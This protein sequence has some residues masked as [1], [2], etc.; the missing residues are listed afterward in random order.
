MTLDE[1]IQKYNNG[2]WDFDGIYSY[3]CKDLFSYFNR[4]VANNPTYIYGNAYEMYNNAPEALYEKIPKTPNFIPQKGDWCV[5]EQSYGGWGHIGMVISA[6]INTQ[7]IMSQNSGGHQDAVNIKRYNYHKVKGYLR[8]KGGNMGR[9]VWDNNV[10]VILTRG[11]VEEG[12]SKCEFPYTYT[13]NDSWGYFQKLFDFVQNKYKELRA[14]AQKYNDLYKSA[15]KLK[16][17][18]EKKLSKNDELIKQL[19]D[20]QIT[21][22]H[23]KEVADKAVN[24]YIAENQKTGLQLIISGIIKLFERRK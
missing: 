17:T 5:W 24:K 23:D 8:L 13:G 21:K 4:D 20:N 15:K 1:F 19:Q 12:S 16:D 22:K 11:Q 3:Q 14:E 18:A 7:D 9:V 10:E 6:N 2:S